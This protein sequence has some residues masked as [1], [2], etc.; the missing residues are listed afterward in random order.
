[1][2]FIPLSTCRSVKK[3]E[4]NVNTAQNNVKRPT[5]YRLTFHSSTVIIAGFFF[6]LIMNSIVERNLSHLV[7]LSLLIF[8]T[9][10]S[11]NAANQTN[12]NYNDNLSYGKAATGNFSDGTIGNVTEGKNR[13][14]TETDGMVINGTDDHDNL[15]SISNDD[16]SLQT[17][18]FQYP[19]TDSVGND[20]S[21]NG[22]IRNEM[23]VTIQKSVNQCACNCCIEETATTPTMETTTKSLCP[24]K[25]VRLF[26]RQNTSL[27]GE[28]RF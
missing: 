10:T 11:S 9:A 20:N 27:R 21:N 25:A 3:A 26:V 15:N 17:P 23:N 7:L 16:G 12:F 13:I 18:L 28:Q 8:S 19:T 22:T 24:G 1:M 14:P 2:S 5:S 4:N 6:S